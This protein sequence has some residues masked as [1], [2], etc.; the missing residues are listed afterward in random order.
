MWPLRQRSCVP[1]QLHLDD[2][3]FWQQVVKAPA[4][5]TLF[6]FDGTLVEIAP[7]PGDVQFR[8]RGKH[9][10]HKI[11]SLPGCRVGVVSGRSIDDL[12][13]LIGLDGIF[14]VGCHGL[15]WADPDGNRYVSWPNRVFIDALASLRA[16]MRETMAGLSGIVVED[17]GLSLALHYRM[18]ERDVAIAA[19]KEFVRAVSWYQQQGVKLQLLAGKEVIEARPLGSTKGDAVTQIWARYAPT[20]LPIYVGD[21]VTDES[22]FIAIADTGLT[23]LVAETPRASAA[24]LFLRNPREVHMFLNC[25]AQMRHRSELIH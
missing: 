4:I 20:A 6:D 24:Q 15:E 25:L 16:E 10:L 18:A 11:V 13:R 8:R 23:I 14:Y 5:L 1:R 9:W 12:R 19:R 3:K 7:T 22:A 2:I 17:K 21:D